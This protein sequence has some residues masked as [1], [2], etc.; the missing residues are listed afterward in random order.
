VSPSRRILLVEDNPDVR[1]FLSDLLT[2]A[3]YTVTTADDGQHAFELLEGGLLPRLM[4]VDLMLPRISGWDLLK[5]AQEDPVLRYI[6][7]VIITGVPRAN[8]RAVADAVF[9]KPFD[10]QEV[11][12]TVKTL[13]DR[14]M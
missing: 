11:L 9:T 7:K 6:P 5:H 14:T 10:T 12:A 8:V 3:G 4:V 2:D 1:I 13:I